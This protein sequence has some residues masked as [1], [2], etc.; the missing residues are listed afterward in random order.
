M[1]EV[2]NVVTQEITW[3]K[4][5]KNLFKWYDDNTNGFRD[6]FDNAVRGVQK[7][8]LGI[9]EEVKFDWE[10]ADIKT[11]VSFFLEW[12]NF[13]PAVDTGLQ[14]IEK[15]SWLYY[16]N[17]AGLE[18]VTKRDKPK[19]NL[20][21]IM[22]R[23]FVDLKA[24]QMDSSDPAYQILINDWIETLG[25]KMDDY[26]EPHQYKTFNKFFTRELKPGKRPISKPTDDSVVVSPADAVINMIDDNLTLDGKL[27]VKTQQLS[28][29]QLL[30]GS[31]LA[32]N[33]AGGTAISCILMP[34]VYHHFHSPVKGKVVESHDDVAGDYFGIENFPKLINGGNV[35]YGYDYSVFEHFRRGYLI[36]QT[37]LYGLVAM[38]PVGLNT[39]ASVVFEDKLKCIDYGDPAVD[40][41]KGE[42][43]GYFQYG[44][45]MNIL[46]FEENVFP[47]VRIPQG[48][49]IG[50]ML[51]K[52]DKK[53]QFAF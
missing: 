2:Q 9:K 26:V 48:Q 11:L 51:E 7:I 35:G 30:N 23:D 34:D 46:L 49:M 53:P 41:L 14:Y 5:S 25:A 3:D 33:F 4:F 19:V 12:Y 28:V 29:N 37:E 36:I 1:Q 27:N 13:L 22:T 10:N 24:T 6:A 17:G 15:F 18:F 38:I 52:E 8:P 45:S 44:G 20:G 40:I 32:R 50:S 43:V 21:Y 16:K 47:S 31:P 42:K 39:I